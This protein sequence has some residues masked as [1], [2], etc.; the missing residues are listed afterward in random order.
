VNSSLTTGFLSHLVFIELKKQPPSLRLF[1]GVC[2]P[3]SMHHVAEIGLLQLLLLLRRVRRIFD[4]FT[5]A[6]EARGLDV[7]KIW[8]LI[9][10]LIF[11]TP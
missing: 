6:C 8:V 4:N 11:L 9:P 7:V 1:L 5:V 3:L 2:L 10:I